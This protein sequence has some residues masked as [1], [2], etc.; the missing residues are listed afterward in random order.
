[1]LE[2]F[3]S[4]PLVPLNGPRTFYPPKQRM[5]TKNF[6]KAD[7]GER[8]Q[9]KEDRSS[10]ASGSRRPSGSYRGSGNG[11]H[12]KDN[13]DMYMKRM[14]PVRNKREELVPRFQVD[15]THLHVFLY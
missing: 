3:A 10:S 8:L 11:Y 12:Q 15:F 13:N 9:D 14:H 1:M 2:S 6:V 7:N 4:F 5:Q